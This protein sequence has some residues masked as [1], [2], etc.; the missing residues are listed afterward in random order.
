FPQF[1]F[2]FSSKNDYLFSFNSFVKTCTSTYVFILNNDLRL[3]PNILNVALPV[4]EKD[5]NLFAVTCTLMDWEG[6]ELQEAVKTAQI[7][8]G[9]LYLNTATKAPKVPTYSFNACGGASIYRTEMFNA[10]G[11]FD[12][13]YRPAYYEDTDLSH[14]AWNRGWATIN[15]PQAI[16][17]HRTG[18][19]WKTQKKK[20]E[21]EQMIHRN[22]IIGMVRNTRIAGFLSSF[23]F[24]LPIRLV[25]STFTD[26]NYS[27][28]LWN[29]VLVLP[30]V[31]KKRSTEKVDNSSAHLFLEL[32]GKPYLSVNK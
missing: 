24:R 15:I 17:W 11:G 1:E 12:P 27:W 20:D 26:R 16:V 5:H 2:H 9:W 14:R 21:L 30:N 25:V 19:S 4:M 28:G 10:F 29:S 32:P 23:L 7:K 22:K 18:G 8:S 6:Q 13:L 31:L 3:S